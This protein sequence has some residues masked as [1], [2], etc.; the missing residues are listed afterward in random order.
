M[1]MILS[2]SQQLSWPGAEYAGAIVTRRLSCGAVLLVAENCVALDPL[3]PR[4]MSG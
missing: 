2:Y 4:R 1:I 3:H